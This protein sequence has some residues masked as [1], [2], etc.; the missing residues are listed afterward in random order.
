MNKIILVG[1]ISQDAKIIN[2]GDGKSFV[3]IT[4]CDSVF[5]NGENKTM[6]LPVS[7]NVSSKTA[8]FLK[9]G[10]MVEIEGHISVDDTHKMYLNG[11]RINILVF[12]KDAPTDAPTKA[13]KPAKKAPAPAPSD[14]DVADD[15]LPF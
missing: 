15:D 10:A 4:V 5:T 2:E 6:F 8:T 11:D 9:K 1:R 3:G 14:D 13:K 12:A 7:V